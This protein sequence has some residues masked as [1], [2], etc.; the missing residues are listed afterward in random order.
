VHSR[1]I[2]YIRRYFNAPGHCCIHTAAPPVSLLVYPCKYSKSSRSAGQKNTIVYL[3]KSN[4][5]GELNPAMIIS[6]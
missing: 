4:F 6:P 3:K 5:K 1:L 2:K